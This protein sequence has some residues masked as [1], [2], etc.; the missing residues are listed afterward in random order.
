MTHLLPVV[1][2]VL[3]NSAVD[4]SAKTF[5]AGAYAIDITPPKFPVIV[6]GMFE[7]RTAE[8]AQDPLHARC[9]VFDDGS[10]RV[11]IAFVDSC[12]QPRGLVQFRSL[13]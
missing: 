1:I 4:D 7:E 2:T 9:L 11:V 6:N 10:S 13:P 5:R 3:F 12:G 8:R